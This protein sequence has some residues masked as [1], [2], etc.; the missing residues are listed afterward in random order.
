MATT[1]ELKAIMQQLELVDIGDAALYLGEEVMTLEEAPLSTENAFAF[2]ATAEEHIASC[3]AFP[4]G[5]S[6]PLL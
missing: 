1:G 5:C 6:T 2:L 3:N 4:V